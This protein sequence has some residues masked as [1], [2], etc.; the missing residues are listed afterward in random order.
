MYIQELSSRLG[1]D[2]I[3]DVINRF[4]IVDGKEFNVLSTC[5]RETCCF[6]SRSISSRS[7]RTGAAAD[8]RNHRPGGKEGN[9]MYRES[10]E[11]TFVAIGGPLDPLSERS[12][13]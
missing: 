13:S 9:V 10:V 11:N 12:V 2:R 3:P 5:I 1:K 8:D 4:T 7:K 6:P